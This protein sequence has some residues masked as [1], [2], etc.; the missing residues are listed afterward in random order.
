M[1][2]V[3][4]IDNKYSILNIDRTMKS[5]FGCVLLLIVL[6]PCMMTA[7]N[8]N[9]DRKELSSFLTRMYN[10][11]PF[12]GVKIVTDY[13]HSYLL[14]IISLDSAKY[15]NASIMNRAASVKAMSEASRYFNGSSICSDMIIHMTEHPDGTQDTDILE[16]I[17]ERSAGYVKQLE[18][19]TTFPRSD[20]WQVYIYCKQLER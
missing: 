1:T 5:F 15:V 16:T 4:L 11:E 14:S 6:C 20:G 17:R 8:Y 19:L 10:S 13:D 9:S 7:Q 2:R 18:L 12:D 3:S